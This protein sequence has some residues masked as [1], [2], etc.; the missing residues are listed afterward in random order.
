MCTVFSVLYPNFAETRVRY[1]YSTNHP[2]KTRVLRTFP[3]KK[4]D[5]ADGLPGI[6]V[7]TAP[8]TMNA[9][10]ISASAYI[11]FEVGPIVKASKE[12][13]KFPSPFE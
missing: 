3:T 13:E 10:L 4:I 7:A 9:R 5:A 2:H 1:H 12:D 11:I 8:S 6:A